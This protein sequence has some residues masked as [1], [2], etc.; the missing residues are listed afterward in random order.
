MIGNDGDKPS[1]VT[2]FRYF[3]LLGGLT[4]TLS[5]YFAPEW[6]GEYMSVDLAWTLGF[7]LLLLLPIT[8]VFH[9]G[10]QRMS[11]SLRKSGERAARKKARESLPAWAEIHGLAFRE[12]DGRDEV[13]TALGDYQ[14][15]KVLVDLDAG[16][17]SARW[18]DEFDG[19]AVDVSTTPPP[20]VP[21]DEMVEFDTGDKG[22]DEVFAT[23]FADE[24][25]A[26]ALGESDAVRES[27]VE[28]WD[29]FAGQLEELNVDDE[30]VVCF[31]APETQYDIEAIAALVDALVDVM[32]RVEDGLAV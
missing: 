31:L 19:R 12:A 21:P 20:T 27:I 10:G 2:A 28:F 18:T 8:M 3:C 16:D 9:F 24:A 29:E 4:L 11:R 6:V 23:R 13:G 32:E 30:G 25:T 22:F 26:D 15:Y 7:I 5:A 1:L 17:V 14:G